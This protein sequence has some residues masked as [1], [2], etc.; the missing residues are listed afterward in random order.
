MATILYATTKENIFCK[1]ETL[2]KKIDDL[3]W[4]RIS[5]D[6]KFFRE[7]TTIHENQPILVGYKTARVMPQLNDREVVLLSTIPAR[8]TLLSQALQQYPT[9]IVIGGV[10]ILKHAMSNKHRQYIN[11]V[12]TVRLPITVPDSNDKKKYILDPLLDIKQSGL[13]RLSSKFYIY[14]ENFEQ[15]TIIAEF[16]R[17]IDA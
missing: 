3:E 2:D 13:L 7:F 8:G 16:W 4:M 5:T 15:P 12:I 10:S 11:S 17:P 6:R 9:G 14:S 1:Q